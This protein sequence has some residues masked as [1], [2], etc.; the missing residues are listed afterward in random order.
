MDYS[1]TEAQRTQRLE[2]HEKGVLMRHVSCFTE[3][4]DTVAARRKEIFA[5]KNLGALCA[6]VV[7]LPFHEQDTN[8]RAS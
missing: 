5:P 6:S 1:T 8:L 4:P 3:F 2:D 7:N